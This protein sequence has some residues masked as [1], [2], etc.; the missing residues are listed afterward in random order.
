MNIS[1]AINACLN[2]HNSE[3][4]AIGYS[5]DGRLYKYTRFEDG[6]CEVDYCAIGGG[7]QPCTTFPSVVVWAPLR[8]VPAYH[9]GGCPSSCIKCSMEEIS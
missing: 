2:D 3:R 6:T 5:P 8:A 1:D 7:W 4:H 9:C